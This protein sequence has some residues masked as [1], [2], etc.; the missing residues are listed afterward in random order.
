MYH[1]ELS[2]VGFLLH[3]TYS[4]AASWMNEQVEAADLLL[5]ETPFRKL[6]LV[7][8]QITST[9]RVPKPK[10]AS[11]GLEPMSSLFVPSSTGLRSDFNNKIV[12]CISGESIYQLGVRTRAEQLTHQTRIQTPHSGNRLH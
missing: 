9:Q 11:E 8:E 2:Q 6:D 3:V 4:S 5:L 1:S 7:R 10:L 12:I